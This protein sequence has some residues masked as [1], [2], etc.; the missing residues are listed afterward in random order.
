M[1]Q[2]LEIRRADGTVQIST[3]EGL[4]TFRYL[5]SHVFDEY[6]DGSESGVY[7]DEAVG[8][9]EIVYH[10]ERT[11]DPDFAHHYA[12]NVLDVPTVNFNEGTLTYTKPT[13]NNNTGVDQVLTVNM[14]HFS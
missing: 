6:T 7:F 13:S 4:T 9:I 1:A 5:S 2:G 12:P 11:G 10:A 8:T 3:E 14:Y